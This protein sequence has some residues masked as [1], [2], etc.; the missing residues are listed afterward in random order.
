ME[1]SERSWTAFLRLWLVLLLSYSTLKF[2]FN[3]VVAGYIDMRPVAFWE[4]L[5]L[6]FGQAIV[7]WLVTRVRRVG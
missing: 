7:F 6:P 1:N 2:V 4:L 5:A 3:V